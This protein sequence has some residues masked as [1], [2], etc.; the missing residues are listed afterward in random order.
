MDIKELKDRNNIEDVIGKYIELSPHAGELRGLCCFHDERTPS[1]MVNPRKQ[2][3][4]CFG[5]GAAGDVLD[6][7]VKRG[8]Q[9]HEAVKEL[10]D[11]TGTGSPIEKKASTRQPVVQWK[12]VAGQMVYIR[13]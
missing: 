6:F 11:P 3:F 12:D 1:L 9:F 5:C 2:I 10:E 4:K 7:L 13:R 8:M